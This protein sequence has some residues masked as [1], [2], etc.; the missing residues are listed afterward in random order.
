MDDGC[1]Y[2]LLSNYTCQPSDVMIRWKRILSGM[3]LTQ[4]NVGFTPRSQIPSDTLQCI[5]QNLI[6]HQQ[7]NYQKN[8]YSIWC[9]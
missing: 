8:C 2:I 3:A 9:Y 6:Y 1:L 4:T 5:K 7:Q